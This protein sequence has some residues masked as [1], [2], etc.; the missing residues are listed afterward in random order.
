M[1]GDPL[2]LWPRMRVS[3]A[4]AFEACAGRGL[5]MRLFEGYRSEARQRWL[6]AQGRTRPGPIVTYLKTPLRHGAG[7]AADCYPVKNGEIVFA[8]TAAELNVW[9]ASMKLHSLQPT[10][11]KGDFGHAQLVAGAEEL[12]AAKAWCQAGFPAGGD[13]EME[14]IAVTVNGT[15]QTAVIKAW[16]T[17]GNTVLDVTD[18]WRF[19]DYPPPVFD[20]AR[21]TLH[22]STQK[23][24]EAVELRELARL[25][26]GVPEGWQRLA[27]AEQREFVR[28]T[29]KLLKAEEAQD[30]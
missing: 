17:E 22:L 3:L 1:D 8:F 7:C 4:A 30:G 13:E 18:W 12:K 6:Y 29:V 2:H 25:I 21:N 14:R 11:L 27:E 28:L 16:L 9:R 20:A 26:G 15:P 5:R 23:V 10:R 24:G 19:A